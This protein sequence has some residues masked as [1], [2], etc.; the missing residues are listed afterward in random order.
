MQLDFSFISNK[1]CSS[2]YT[3]LRLNTRL[4]AAV[5]DCLNGIDSFLA[6]EK[7]ISMISMWCKEN[8]LELNVCKRKELCID[9]CTSGQFDGPLCIGGE[10]L[11]VTD[12]FKYLG[13][14]LDN[15]MMFGPHVWSPCLVPMIGPHV[16]GVYKKCQQRLYL[17][18]KLR[19]IH[20]D[21]KLLLL[22][23]RSV[24]ESVLTCCSI[25]FSLLCLSHTKYAFPHLQNC[26]QDNRLPHTACL[27]A[28]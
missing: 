20:V 12:T 11:K 16:Q 23:Y 6:Y 5:V 10:A 24:I 22:L 3:N 1:L 9:F 7:T 18:R 21:P 28:D 8:F 14:T 4:D 27:S 25:C 15:Q 19:S 13:V 17:L 26:F 2:L